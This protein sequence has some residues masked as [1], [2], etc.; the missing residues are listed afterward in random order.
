MSRKIG[1]EQS[2]NRAAVVEPKAGTA[3]VAATVALFSDLGRFNLVMT[4]D[5]VGQERRCR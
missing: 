3:T 5:G 1:I 2:A 4:I